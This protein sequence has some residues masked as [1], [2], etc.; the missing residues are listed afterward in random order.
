MGPWCRD[1][2]PVAVAGDRYRG[3]V[4]QGDPGVLRPPSLDEIAPPQGPPAGLAVLVT[5][6]DDHPRS[7]V[8]PQ[9]AEGPL[10]HPVL[11]VPCPASQQQVEL[12]E[13]LA[14]GLVHALLGDRLDL[15]AHRCHR[16]SG[17]EGI[18]KRLRRPRL[19]C[20][21]MRNPR[22]SN[23]SSMWTTRVFST[24]RRNPS[25]ARTSVVC[26]YSAS[27]CS[28]FPDTKMTRSSA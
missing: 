7:G 23:P 6:P 18:D 26:C 25:G 8:V 22:K 13:N 15:P 14:E 4:E 11:E 3:G 17:R 20:R 28:R 2:A 10:G 24:D 1:V 12:P 16:L 27:A 19:R 5:Q 21:W 9:V